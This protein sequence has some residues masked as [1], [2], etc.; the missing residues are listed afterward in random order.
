LRDSSFLR[1]WGENSFVVQVNRD[2]F[3]RLTGCVPFKD[4]ADRYGLVRIDFEPYS[5]DD[6][7]PMT[8]TFGLTFNL[9]TLVTEHSTASVE[10]VKRALLYAAKSLLCQLL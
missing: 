10:A 8:I 6:R 4:S 5:L 3:K 1:L 9:D 2:A 7:P